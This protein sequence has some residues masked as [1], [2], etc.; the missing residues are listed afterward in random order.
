MN[1]KRELIIFLDQVY[2]VCK[3]SEIPVY[4]VGGCVRDNL[5]CRKSTDFDLAIDSHGFEVLCQKLEKNYAI[6]KSQFSTFSINIGDYN[7]DVAAFRMETYNRANGLPDIQLAKI[8]QD[9]N[10][11][12]FTIN[13]G[14]TLMTKS[15]IRVLVGAHLN[16]NHANDILKINY[17]HLHFFEDIENKLIRILHPNSFVEDAS[18]LLRAVKYQV[19]LGLNFETDTQLR[20]NSKLAR[21]A[22]EKFSL[23][24]YKQI[25][26]DYALKNNGKRI[27][28]ALYNEK[29]LLYTISSSSPVLTNVKMDSMMSFDS[30]LA[31]FGKALLEEVDD[32]TRSV[33]FLLFIYHEHIIFWKNQDRSVN[34]LIEEITAIQSGLQVDFICD[35]WHVFKLLQGKSIASILFVSLLI[36]NG[37][38]AIDHPELIIELS[39]YLDKTRFTKVLVTGTDLKNIG[40][41]QGKQIG[42]MLNSLLKYKVNK[43]VNMTINEE[44]NWIASRINEYRD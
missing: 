30:S 7:V 39:I 1:D 40:I 19:T 38:I 29:L 15:S 42:V 32:R 13:T 37:F 28:S 16:R 26:L 8:E 4:F 12:D 24:R 41:N 18:R 14:Y 43:R 35:A 2:E 3:Q 10:R 31:L 20:F 21:S 9:I 11:R 22:L 44:I 6:N 33:L 23:D 36:Q 5:L 27:I 17:S 25:I 34:L